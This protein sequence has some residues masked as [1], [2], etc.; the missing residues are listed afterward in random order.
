M[1]ETLPTARTNEGIECKFSSASAGLHGRFA[2]EGRRLHPPF[3]LEA[4]VGVRM[5]V[6][7]AA[8]KVNLHRFNFIRLSRHSG[9]AVL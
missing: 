6:G 9:G 4:E 7:R 8:R 3:C 1:G 5:P 2:A